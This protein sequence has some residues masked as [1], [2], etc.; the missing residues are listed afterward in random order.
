MNLVIGA[1]T[2]TGAGDTKIIFGQ[3]D[4][5][6]R[7]IKLYNP[8]AGLRIFRLAGARGEE[9]ST[10]DGD[11]FSYSITG[12]DVDGDGYIDYVAAALHGD[13][14]DNLL[15]SAGNVYIFSG[16]KLS[17]KLGFAPT[18]ITSVTARRKS[19]GLLT[20]KITGSN[21]PIGGTVTASTNGSPLKLKGALI[22]SSNSASAKIRRVRHR[23][24][25][26]LSRFE[27]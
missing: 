22:D 8:P 15:R 19:S 20:L 21:F 6:P 9:Q 14:V 2:R 1:Q 26:R 4:F 24:P 13:G 27:W 17:T 12:G 25:E 11:E 5:L 7:V 23:R 16:K 3:R 10:D 18:E